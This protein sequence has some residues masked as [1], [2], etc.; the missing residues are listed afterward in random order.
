MR[1][2]IEDALLALRQQVQAWA[3]GAP[4]DV[5]VFVYPPEWEA[6]ML[7]RLPIW[8]DARA[9]EGLAV[10][11]VDVGQEFAAQVDFGRGQG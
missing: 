7:A 8:A 6:L 1:R 3:G 11:L 10:E 9:A 5:R 2:T 4:A